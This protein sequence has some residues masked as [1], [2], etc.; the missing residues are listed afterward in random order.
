MCSLYM[1][2]LPFVVIFI[3]I[4]FEIGWETRCDEDE[5]GMKIEDWWRFRSEISI[6][7]KQTDRNGYLY[8]EAITPKNIVDVEI[9]INKCQSS[10]DRSVC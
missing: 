5:E 4:S 1:I 3:N 7:R 2:S 6:T 10:S 8:R 9:T